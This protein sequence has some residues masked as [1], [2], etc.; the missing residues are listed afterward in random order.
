M[1]I[2]IMRLILDAVMAGIVTCAPS[3]P[4]GMGAIGQ[5]PVGRESEKSHPRIEAVFVLDTTGSMSGLINAAKEKIWAI[6]S[7]LGQ[8]EPAP[9]IRIGLVGYR[10]RGD[11]YITRVTPLSTDLDRVYSDLM[12]YRAAGGGDGPESVNQA[13]AAAVNDIRWSS[14]VSTYRV[15]FLVGDYPPHMDYENDARYPETC[16]SA[17]RRGIIINTVQCGTYG[18]TTPVWREI[19]SLAGGSSSGSNSRGGR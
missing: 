2:N 18:P 9:E 5:V 15:I 14:D 8:S 6:A 7:T 16:R 11:E 4:A 10:D 1:K 12:A 3:A 17:G 13:L 19:A